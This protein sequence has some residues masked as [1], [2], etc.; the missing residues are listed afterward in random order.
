MQ[1]WLTVMR[2]ILQVV[3]ILLIAAMFLKLATDSAYCN[4]NYGGN[5]VTEMPAWCV[6]YMVR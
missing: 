1:D 4:T 2:F 3:F 6:R 5:A